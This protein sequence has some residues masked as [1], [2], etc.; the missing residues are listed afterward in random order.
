MR[1]WASA[2]HPNQNELTGFQIISWLETC[3]KEVIGKE[4]AG[5]VVE[6]KR[7]LHNIRNQTLTPQD[8]APISRS[9]EPLP[10]DLAISLLRTI[11]GMYTD[12]NLPA[13]TKNNIKLVAGFVW[14]NNSEEAKQEIGLKYAIF[15][16][17]ADIS[18]RDLAKEFLT[19]VNGL[20]YLPHDTLAVELD[21]K[22][23]NLYS[24]HI[25]YNNFHN[26]PS[27]AKALYSY[28]PKTG[29]I[30]DSVRYN[31]VKTLVMCHIGNGY[32]ISHLAYQY[33][34]ELIDRFQDPEI[35]IIVNLTQDKEFTSR[36]QFPSCSRN[37]KQLIQRVKGKTS[38]QRVIDAINYLENRTEQQLST[39]GSSTEMKRL[40]GIK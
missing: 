24:A 13:T 23:S 29:M 36:L 10:H 32:G 22:I 17:N 9:L 27:H 40:L 1:N 16:A 8:I 6:V 35:W 5:Q 12:M 14:N 20:S 37:F 15:A 2:A 7:L 25:G 34:N 11:F 4:P 19:I 30:P 26:E 31:Y 28:V 21:L 18:R 39:V 3:I 38:K 33:Y